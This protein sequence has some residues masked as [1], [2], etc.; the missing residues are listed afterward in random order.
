MV[1]RT[2]PLISVKRDDQLVHKHLLQR[3]LC[4]VLGW[5]AYRAW[6][7]GGI[8]DGALV[9]SSLCCPDSTHSM[10]D[11]ER[12]RGAHKQDRS[13]ELSSPLHFRTGKRPRQQRAGAE[14]HPGLLPA[15]KA[16][17]IS[18][19]ASK[20]MK[21]FGATN[22]PCGHKAILSGAGDVGLP[23]GGSLGLKVTVGVRGLTRPAGAQGLQGG[24]GG[25][26]RPPPIPQRGEPAWQGPWCR[27][28]RPE[29]LPETPSCV[30]PSRNSL[31]CV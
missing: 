8:S 29:S 1:C 7:T 10:P 23:A 31:L 22:C 21:G 15:S 3:A 24:A 5:W 9:F 25:A 26:E 27:C 17:L 14:L 2:R 30:V 16:R 20:S 11:P 13:R 18:Q 19:G 4:Q 6:S 12:L 28:W